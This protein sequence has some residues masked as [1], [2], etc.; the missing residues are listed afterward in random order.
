[1]IPFRLLFRG[2]AFVTFLVNMP[3]LGA[4][5]SSFPPR[6]ANVWDGMAHEPNPSLVTAQERAAGIG[7]RP[8]R[9]QAETSEVE[10]HCERLLRD[11]GLTTDRR[12]WRIRTQNAVHQGAGS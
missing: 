2:V 7:L 1:M 9:E 12:S 11:E 8:E 3:A 4:P 10:T 6:I 5:M